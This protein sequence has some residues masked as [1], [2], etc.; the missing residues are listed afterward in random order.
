[1]GKLLGQKI[2]KFRDILPYKVRITGEESKFD[3][4]PERGEGYRETE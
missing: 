2:C 3:M 4:K 1:M